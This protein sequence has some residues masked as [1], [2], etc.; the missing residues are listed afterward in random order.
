MVGNNNPLP[1]KA[2]WTAPP[3]NSQPMIATH[4]NPYIQGWWLS[5]DSE[6]SIQGALPSHPPPH[7]HEQQFTSFVFTSSHVLD[8]ADVI[9][10]LN[11]P[12]FNVSTSPGPPGKGGFTVLQREGR[13]IGIV[14]WTDCTVEIRRSVEK[15][16]LK[17]WLRLLSEDKCV[18]PCDTN[19]QKLNT[20]LQTSIN[21]SQRL[22]LY[23]GTSSNRRNCGQ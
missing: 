21:G 18:E 4:C 11:Q 2:I 12:Y 17:K 13:N 1:R 5:R 10:P 19:L 7:L 14:D 22:A 8:P 3:M 20:S 9:G 23:L 16:N 6:I 15:Q